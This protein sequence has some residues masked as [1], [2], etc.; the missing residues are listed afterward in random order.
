MSDFSLSDGAP[1]PAET[2]RAGDLPEPPPDWFSQFEAELRISDPIYNGA[3]YGRLDPARPVMP[4]FDPFEEDGDG[5]LVHLRGYEGFEDEFVRAVSPADLAAIKR[6]IDGELEARE[7]LAR[8]GTVSGLTAGLAAGVI[9]PTGILT[10]LVP[11][12]GAAVAASRGANALRTA[13]IAVGGTAAAGVAREALEARTMATWS[14]EEARTELLMETALAGVLGGAIGGLRAPVP[15]D[16]IDRLT[17]ELRTPARAADDLMMPANGQRLPDPVRVDVPEFRPDDV[18][19]IDEAPEYLSRYAGRAADD[20]EVPS[21]RFDAGSLAQATARAVGRVLPNATAPIALRS[22][23]L[24]SAE[25]SAALRDLLP[26]LRR[27]TERP[28]RVIADPEAPTERAFLAFRSGDDAVLVGVRDGVET[29]DVDAIRVMPAQEA[30]DFGRRGEASLRA[31]RPEMADAAPDVL[32]PRNVAELTEFPASDAAPGDLSAAAAPEMD[33]RMKSALGLER[34]VKFSTPILRAAQSMAGATRRTLNKLAEVPWTLIDNEAGVPSPVAV[35]T[36]V[37]G[38]QAPLADALAI[39]DEAFVRYRTGNAGGG[40]VARLRVQA[41]DFRARGSGRKLS[42]REFKAKVGLAMRRGD[43]DPVPEVQEVA[44]EMR[45]RLFD[46]MKDEAIKL[47]L[48]PEDVEVST[49]ASYLTRVWNHERL[50]AKRPEFKGIVQRWFQEARENARLDLDELD[51]RLAAAEVE[52]EQARTSRENMTRAAAQARQAA[53]A[54]RRGDFGGEVATAEAAF[55]VDDALRAMEGR[56]EEARKA[57]RMAL[58]ERDRWERSQRELAEF[59]YLTDAEIDAII[60]EVIDELTNAPAGRIQYDMTA[61]PRGPL[62]ARTFG[63]PD[64][65]VED[66]LES[67]IEVVARHFTNTMAPDIELSRAFGRP[68]MEVQLREIS[69]DWNRQIE[70]APDEATRKRLKNGRES[71]LEDI[72][73]MRDRLR[74]TYKAPLSRS[75]RIFDRTSQM[76][77]Q[78][79]FLRLMGGMTISSI[80]DVARPV[81]THGL[82]RVFG[83]ALPA[84]VGDFKGYRMGAEEARRAAVG[85]DMVLDSRAYALADIVDPYSGRTPTERGL[86]AAGSAFSVATLMSPW[87]AALRQFSGFMTQARIADDVFAWR[88]GPLPATERTYLAKLGIDENVA[89]RIAEQLERHGEQRNGVWVARTDRWDDEARAARD[90]FRAAVLKDSD[91]TVVVPGIGDRPLMA[92][93]PLGRLVFQFKSFAFA[94]MQRA[95]IPALQDRDLNVLAGMTMATGLGMMSYVAYMTASGRELSDN[96]ADWL[97]EG[98]DRSGMLAWLFEVNNTVEKAT[99]GTVGIGPLIGA[100]PPSRYLSRNWA[101]SLAGPSA[102]LGEDASRAMSSVFELGEWNSSDTRRIR[103]L[104]PAQNLFYMRRVLDQAEDGLNETLG[105]PEPGR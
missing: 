75:G 23:V 52:V 69:E 44:Q 10:N 43:T 32:P 70:A 88:R 94:S 98:V 73:A 53:N 101:A 80:A 24:R 82:G 29:L 22:S 86:Q 15:R 60:D 58:Q 99:A 74:G 89:A 83:K 67:D 39:M 96:P 81:F 103:R 95:L 38:W 49:A 33:A 1:F 104:L 7:T 13:G 91:R 71:D 45:A 21:V 63:I 26:Q 102:G 62:K 68:D 92:S 54:A 40:R 90:T 17:R 27:L 105:I 64:L 35:E 84:L 34:A 72:G 6:R 77:S 66:F 47:G 31:A 79:N 57:E 46:P 14:I 18:R 56:A 36:R 48:L 55:G 19:R 78:W 8:A 20:P 76:V 42:Y 12:G 41:A 25:D 61:G 37:K 100:S 65:L 9:G 87:N 5:S 30:V 85:L 59:A 11:V 3:R 28:V 2:F 50:N 97:R 16:A 51:A 93:G 4:G